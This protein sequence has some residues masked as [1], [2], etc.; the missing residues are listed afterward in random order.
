MNKLKYVAMACI[1]SFLTVTFC[2]SCIGDPP[3]QNEASQSRISYARNNLDYAIMV[4]CFYHPLGDTN[5]PILWNKMEPVAWTEPI[6]INPNE[7]KI[8][9]DYVD[10]VIIKV[11]RSADTML[12]YKADNI[13][14]WPWLFQNS[15]LSYSTIDASELGNRLSSKS[16]CIYEEGYYIQDNKYLFENIP[17]DIYPIG[18]GD[19]K[20]DNWEDRKS[21]YVEQANGYAAISCI[22]FDKGYFKQF[23]DTTNIKAEI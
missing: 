18:L 3:C 4:Q 22:V 21:V 8:I 9:M 20:P 16:P 23:A 15:V 11:Y 7:R 19:Y 1:I 5:S 6:N 2:N 12:L 17:W 14:K 10:P 13:L